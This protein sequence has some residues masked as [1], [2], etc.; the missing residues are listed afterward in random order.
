MKAPLVEGHD[1]Y[2]EA[3]KMV[4]T[5]SYHLRRGFC[6]HSKCRHCPY[7]NAPGGNARQAGEPPIVIVGLSGPIKLPR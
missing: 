2:L 6:C 7:G 3:G 1:Y 4:L 5:E